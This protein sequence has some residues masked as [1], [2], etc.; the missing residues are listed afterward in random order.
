MLSVEILCVG[1]LKERYWTEA[2][3]EYTKRLQSFCKLRITEIP[4]CR[5]GDRPTGGEIEKVLETEGNAIL[6]KISPSAYVIPMCIEG[7]IFIFRKVGGNIA[8]CSNRWKKSGLLCH[9][10]ILW[11]VRCGET[12]R[13]FA[14]FCVS[15]D[16]SSSTV[17][18]YAVRANISGFFHQC[19]YPISQIKRDRKFPVLFLANLGFSFAKKFRMGRETAVWLQTISVK[20]T[21]VMIAIGVIRPQKDRYHIVSLDI[22]I[23]FYRNFQRDSHE[24]FLCYLDGI[25][26]GIASIDLNNKLRL[27]HLIVAVRIWQI[28]KNFKA[29]IQCQLLM[30]WI[31]F[32]TAP[33][34]GTFQSK[35]ILSLQVVKFAD[36]LGLLFVALFGAAPITT[37]FS[38]RGI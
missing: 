30:N 12:P 13:G 19:P 7:K 26:L 29:A 8:E 16:I 20:D 9:W 2:V 25:Y 18:H 37:K 22:K 10:R 15:Y 38:Q 31:K 3:A 35:E 14:A 33:I 28:H 4:E 36:G 24:H 23:F 1:R 11:P 17:S 34:A 32:C 6:Q 21:L 5:V 27:F